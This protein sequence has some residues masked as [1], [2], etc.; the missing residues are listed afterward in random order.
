MG[1]L[2]AQRNEE[3]GLCQAQ[4]KGHLSMAKLQE[5]TLSQNC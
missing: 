4:A 2:A 1:V 5:Q 3:E